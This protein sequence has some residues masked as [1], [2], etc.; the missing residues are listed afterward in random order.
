LLGNL[1]NIRFNFKKIACVHTP[2]LSNGA[3]GG[4]WYPNTVF[5]HDVLIVLATS[6]LCDGVWG[7]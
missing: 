1:I 5:N 7:Q 3:C 2:H 6:P 4:F